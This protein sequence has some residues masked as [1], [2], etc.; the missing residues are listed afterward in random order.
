VGMLEIFYP[1][2]RPSI[3]GTDLAPFESQS[4]NNRHSWAIA[5]L[6]GMGPSR[7]SPRWR[8]VLLSSQAKAEADNFREAGS[9]IT[10][11][12]N[13]KFTHFLVNGRR[14]GVRKEIDYLA[15]KRVGIHA[16]G[17]LTKLVDKAKY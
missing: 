3:Y 16:A 14:R 5:Q 8:A 17:D 4:K 15:L 7:L 6:W 12:I 10:L 13:A 1:E 11:W 2:M 9:P